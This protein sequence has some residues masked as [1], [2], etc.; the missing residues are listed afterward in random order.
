MQHMALVSAY[1]DVFEVA[2]LFSFTF[3]LTHQHDVA[4]Q[5]QCLA[6][7]LQAAD[8]AIC[9]MSMFVCL[10]F[11]ASLGAE[12]WSGTWQYCH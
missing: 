8:T 2:S 3:T 6:T 11:V 10:H 12:W 9:S 7:T 5:Q 1:F 4:G